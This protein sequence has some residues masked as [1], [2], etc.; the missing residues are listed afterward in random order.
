MGGGAPGRDRHADFFVAGGNSLSLL[1]LQSVTQKNLGI[2]VPIIRLFGAS[3]LAQMAATFR[4]E[5]SWS[6]TETPENIDWEVPLGFHLNSPSGCLQEMV[7]RARDST[8]VIILT[9]STGFLGQKILE[10]MLLD[11]MISRVHCI[12][13]RK[14]PRWAT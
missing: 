7:P 12:A 9:G 4:D 13:V 1:T 8:A 11:N 2:S 10:G 6:S 14:P 3:T 5:L